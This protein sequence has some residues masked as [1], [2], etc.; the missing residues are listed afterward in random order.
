MMLSIE[1]YEF[2]QTIKLLAEFGPGFEPQHFCSCCLLRRPIRSKHCSACN[3]CVA[4]F[5]HHCPWVGNCI[6][7]IMFSRIIGRINISFRITGLKNHRHFIYYLF[8]LSFSCLL[9][10]I[11]IV[12][13]WE[14]QCTS[15]TGSASFLQLMTELRLIFSFV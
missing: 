5:D 6:G 7:T 9:F 11:G 4:R 12:S 8:F 3:K 14:E 10:D 13:F 1:L 15:Y 2:F